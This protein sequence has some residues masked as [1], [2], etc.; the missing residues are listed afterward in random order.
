[1]KNNPVIEIVDVVF[2][3]VL[4]DQPHRALPRH[5]EGDLVLGQAHYRAQ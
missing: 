4:F 1:M 2:V 5:T 3:E